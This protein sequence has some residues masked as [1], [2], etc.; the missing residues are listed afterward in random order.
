[1]LVPFIIVAVIASGLLVLLVSARQ[2][3]DRLTAD[4]A[5]L[6][7]R[8]EATAAELASSRETLSKTE[9]TLSK[10][11]AALSK[12][13]GTLSKTAEKLSKSEEKLADVQ[14][15][16]VDRDRRVGDLT[17]QNV[18]LTGEVADLNGRVEEANETLRKRTEL[19]DAQ[20]AQI[21]VLSGARDD[22]QLELTAAEERIVTLT[23]RPEVVVGESG[24]DPGAET[25]W[26]LEVARSERSWRTSVAIDP[27]GETS[28][29]ETTDDPVRTAVEIEASALREDVGALIS[30]DWKAMPIE[31]ASRRLLVVRVAQELLAQASRAPG[32]ARLIVT[33][34]AE[35]G[36]LSF[37]FEA[38]DDGLTLR[39]TP[40]PVSADV[41][42][43]RDDDGL[44]VTV[45]A[46]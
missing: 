40:P 24:N 4:G 8:V 7:E 11:A 44:V 17:S 21:E 10:T 18:K 26:D 19:A 6:A 39:L 20:A 16:L 38:A 25:L 37:S 27:M 28:P 12:T 35:D 33:D 46:D 42:D 23:A 1:M 32:A 3:I 41:I 15:E 2:R 5:E 13:E 45:L 36:S 34:S 30:V 14:A 29:F 31:S 43:V 9:E 22:L